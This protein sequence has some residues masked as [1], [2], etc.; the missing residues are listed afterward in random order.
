MK[1]RDFRLSGNILATLIFSNVFRK[2]HLH[3]SFHKC[4]GFELLPG[5]FD[6]CG[7]GPGEWGQALVFV[8]DSAMRESFNFYFSAV[9][10]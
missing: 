5:G 9:F 7:H 4:G 1:M 3:P 8:W 2:M 6:C 10:C